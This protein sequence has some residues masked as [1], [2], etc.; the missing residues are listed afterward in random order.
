M[1]FSAMWLFLTFFTCC[2]KILRVC[3]FL[4]WRST[5]PQP[6]WWRTRRWPPLTLMERVSPRCHTV[7]HSH[8]GRFCC[9]LPTLIKQNECKNLE[10]SLQHKWHYFL[11]TTAGWKLTPMVGAMYSP[12]LYTGMTSEN[13]RHAHLDWAGWVLFFHLCHSVHQYPASR[14]PRQPRL[15]PPPLQLFEELTSGVAR[16]PS[17]VQWGQLSLSLPS[18]PTRGKKT[19]RDSM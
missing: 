14:T 17:T 18:L 10:V 19:T 11:W 15:L 12:E 6:E 4:V 1:Q 7:T 16:G 8:S 5:M 3:F 9:L 2:F 13:E